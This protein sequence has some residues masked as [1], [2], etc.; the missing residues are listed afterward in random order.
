MKKTIFLFSKTFVLAYLLVVLSSSCKAQTKAY[1]YI[2]SSRIINIPFT[3]INDSVL[4]FDNASDKSIMVNYIN[5]IF[6]SGILNLI[7][8]AK[9]DILGSTSYLKL[10][11]FNDTANFV[12]VAQ[13]IS[14]NLQSNYFRMAPVSGGE[15]H[16]CSGVKCGCCEF[17]KKKGKIIGCL[18][19]PF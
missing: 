6:S 12:I 18:C 15:S 14:L 7:D 5:T 2:N 16:T 9:L 4:I 3:K 19:N 10:L 17:L 13:Q 11:G 8:S 1:R